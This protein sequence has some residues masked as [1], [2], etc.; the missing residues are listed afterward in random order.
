MP[1]ELSYT[2]K[3]SGPDDGDDVR[4]RFQGSDERDK[5]CQLGI[6]MDDLP[7][8]FEHAYYQLEI[9]LSNDRPAET[10][11]VGD[12]QA[13][14][15]YEADRTALIPEEC[16]FDLLR[17]GDD[18]LAGDLSLLWEDVP[19]WIEPE[20]ES[21]YVTLKLTYDH[22][23]TI[24][25]SH[26]TPKDVDRKL[27]RLD[28]TTPGVRNDWRTS[29][30]NLQSISFDNGSLFATGAER[31][32]LAIDPDTGSRIWRQ[33]QGKGH[34]HAK[35]SVV[36]VGGSSRVDVFD[37]AA[38][39]H[40]WSFEPDEWM[41][42]PPA[43]YVPGETAA[44]TAVE[45]PLVV[46][47]T[48][49]GTVYALDA[50][51][52]TVRWRFRADDNTQTTPTIHHGR[53]YVGSRDTTIYGLDLATGDPEW[54]YSLG[55]FPGPPLAG[56]DK[57]LYAVCYDGILYAIDIPSR[58]IIWQ[59]DLGTGKSPLAV[60]PEYLA[61]HDGTDALVL[62]PED[63]TVQQRHTIPYRTR[64]VASSLCSIDDRTLYMASSEINAVDLDDTSLSWRHQSSGRF[65][66]ADGSAFIA[67]DIPDQGLLALTPTDATRLPLTGV[68]ESIDD[69]PDGCTRL[70]L[71][72]DQSLS[73]PCRSLPYYG[74]FRDA[75]YEVFLAIDPAYENVTGERQRNSRQITEFEA[76][77]AEH[78]G[79]RST[80]RLIEVA[81]PG[82]SE[83]TL[84]TDRLPAE[85]RSA[86][87]TGYVSIY[88]EYD[89]DATPEDVKP[90]VSD[91]D[92]PGELQ[93]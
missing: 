5:K 67:S 13:V 35:G 36:A 19:D 33:E 88:L 39:K 11:T 48:K 41:T 73:L 44:T 27:G 14:L 82:E 42:D 12:Y 66:V 51:S 31:D 92:I 78:D 80:L 65:A 15:V 2:V 38:G 54:T 40:R 55:T 62:D 30:T 16:G 17:S 76:T 93:A 57:M 74:E 43:L 86:G 10:T 83:L 61:V 46:F 87:D 70:R 8:Y 75:H 71:P 50:R 68:I 72:E 81:G 1:T 3:I 18:P 91:L 85:M 34:V 64:A 59:V 77:L 25:E 45:E 20:S 24:A 47:G 52:G 22:R 28:R 53:V 32:V 90:D 49:S 63:G 89:E 37:G 23:N 4:F 29:G 69:S 21:G 56:L 7:V 26:L 58:E 6:V 60:T 9:R 84:Q 79:D